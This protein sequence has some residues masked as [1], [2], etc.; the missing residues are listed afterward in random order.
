M[1]RLINELFATS[2][3]IE[4]VTLIQLLIATLLSFGL[5]LIIGYIYRVTHQGP[6]YSQSTVQTMV[7]MGVVVSVIM[8]IIGSNIARAFSLVGALSIIRFRN[9]VKESRDVAF[10]FLTMAIGMASGTGF[11]GIA[12]VF[13]LIMASVIYAMYQFNFGAK[14]TGEVLLKIDIDRDLNY[15]EAFREVFYK[16]LESD[17]LL[18]IDTDDSNRFELVYSVK[19]RKKTSE[20]EF[21]KDLREVSK[22]INAQ[23]IKNDNG[24]FI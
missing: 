4:T 3:A 8:L 19:M 21:L 20:Q 15:K 5:T 14:P 22:N 10:Y 6:S 7:I 2:G 16:H 24:F 13:T 9:A 12:I 1:E 17:S 18:T 11:Y 23:L